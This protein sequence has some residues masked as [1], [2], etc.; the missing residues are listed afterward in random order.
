MRRDVPRRAGVAQTGELTAPRY[1]IEAFYAAFNSGDMDTVCNFLA[2]ELEWRPAFG[3]GLIGGNVYRGK[4]GFR[5]YYTDL[6]DGF[7]RYSVQ[8]EHVETVRP[9]E[10]VVTVRAVGTGRESGI[11]I[12]RHFWIVYEFED[13]RIVRGQTYPDR[14]AAVHRPAE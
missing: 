9:D 12:D 3:Q 10:L 4:A 14:A 7:A 11:E 2:D 8:L 1:V 6:Q 13:G 5:R